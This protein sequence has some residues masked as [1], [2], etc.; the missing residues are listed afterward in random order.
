METRLDRSPKPEEEEAKPSQVLQARRFYVQPDK[1]AFSSREEEISKKFETRFQ[2]WY[3]KNKRYLHALVP[4]LVF[5][6]VLIAVSVIVCFSVVLNVSVFT[7]A[8]ADSDTDETL[9]SETVVM[10]D[11]ADGHMIF[12]F[13]YEG[14]TIGTVSFSS[15]GLNMEAVQGTDGV[16][17]SS[18][19][20]HVSESV[21]P[22]SSGCSVF[23]LDYSET[24]TGIKTGDEVTLT[25][26]YGTLRFSVSDIEVL[27]AAKVQEF[28]DSSS[29]RLAF[30]A[31][32]SGN[33]GDKSLVTVLVCDLSDAEYNT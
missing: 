23:R 18:A 2:R 4:Y 27:D 5:L 33:S 7:G 9:A 29:G 25:A 24:M 10:P 32:H 14:D 15:V 20:G 11:T 1:Q 26:V 31:A 6:F 22:G 21:L 12:P 8:D 19:A 3:K 30:C 28:I 16:D 17:L 13:F